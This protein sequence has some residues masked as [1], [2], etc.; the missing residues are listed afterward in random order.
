MPHKISWKLK[1]IAVTSSVLK[2]PYNM[3][4]LFKIQTILHNTINGYLIL[5]MDIYYFLWIVNISLLNNL[6]SG[7]EWVFKF[8]EKRG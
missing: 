7:I 3:Y 1:V 5:S 8:M 2:L 4:Y 6:N